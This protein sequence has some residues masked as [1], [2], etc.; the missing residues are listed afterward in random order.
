MVTHHG[1]HISAAG[2][3]DELTAAF[4]SNLVDII[5][6]N[7]IDTWYFGHSH[8]RFSSEVAGTR[9]QNVS[10]GYPSEI[11][12]TSEDDLAQVCFIPNQ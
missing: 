6:V 9:I 8:R 10:L 1:P 7:E 4:H 3:V 11:H 5:A 2:K 12:D